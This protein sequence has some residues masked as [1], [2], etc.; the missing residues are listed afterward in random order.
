MHGRSQLVRQIAREICGIAVGLEADEVVVA[1]R[2]NQVLA[3][4]H[5]R[6]DFR[7]RQRDMEEEADPVLMAAPA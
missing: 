2:R 5:R 1:K 7:R 3:V 6:Q 4:R